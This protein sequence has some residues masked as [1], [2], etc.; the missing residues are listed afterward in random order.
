MP[1]VP[2]KA[3]RRARLVFVVIIVR[4]AIALSMM[5]RHDESEGS[6]SGAASNEV[7]S[8]RKK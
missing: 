8:R 6:Y 2:L 3:P 7:V 4:V 5:C 1:E